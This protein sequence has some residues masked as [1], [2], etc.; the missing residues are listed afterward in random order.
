MRIGCHVGVIVERTLPLVDARI[1]AT[2]YELPR[3]LTL[4][5]AD[6]ARVNVMNLS[7]I[8]IIGG[9]M[10]GLSAAVRLAAQGRRVTLIERNDR[11]GG[12]LHLWEAPHPHRPG[13]R[14]FRFDTGPSLITLPFVF[15][16]LFAAAGEKLSDHLQ[17]TRLDP[18]ARYQWADGTTFEACVDPARLREAIE[19]FAPGDFPGWQRFFEQGR[20]TWDLSADL[21]LYHC[22]EQV[23]GPRAVS[24]LP[25]EAPMSSG[26]IDQG[27]QRTGALQA[28]SALSIPIR[29]GMFSRLRRVIDRNIKSPR[30]REILYQY[31]TYSGASPFRAPATLAV[32][33]FAEFHFG[34]YY[35]QGGLYR[36]A[37]ATAALARRMGVEIVTGVDVEQIIVEPQGRASRSDASRNAT[38]EDDSARSDA[39]PRAGRRAARAVGV[40]LSNGTEIRADAVVANSDA[41]FTMSRLIDPRFRRAYPDARLASLDPGGSGMILLLGVD[42]T[43]PQLAHHTKFMPEDYTSDLR[44]MFHTRTIPEDPCIYVAASTR[45]DPTQAPDGCENLFVLASAPALGGTGPGLDWASAGPR[46]RDQLVRTLEHRWG[47]TDLSSRIVVEKTYSPADLARVYNANRGGIY[48]LGS[49]S[50][51][52]AFLRPPNRDKDI[53]R[54]Y[55]VGGATHPGGGLPLVTLSGKIVSELIA[56]DD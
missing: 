5:S 42:R 54:L 22:P 39:P 32:I 55:Y 29:I 50:L 2:P 18:I 33:P 7:H 56:Q 40:R 1:I 12:K 16:Q 43:Y 3:P 35:I 49:D 51:K 36:L 46:Y 48:G 37:E 8:L 17:L 25:R 41:I 31:A 27:P 34:G 4:H 47:L 24:P 52:N 21:F 19:R 15:E 26:V 20:L 13:D 53:D 10:G 38:R 23:F 28:L 6:I 44:A 14:P 9:G 11:I 45:S 30:L